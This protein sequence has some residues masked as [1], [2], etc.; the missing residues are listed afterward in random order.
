M[1]ILYVYVIQQKASP[2][3]AYQTY[4]EAANTCQEQ[5]FSIAEQ[6]SL[7]QRYCLVLEELRREAL[8][9]TTGIGTIHM[10]NSASLSNPNFPEGAGVDPSPTFQ[11]LGLSFAGDVNW[12][13][14]PSSSVADITSWGHFDSLVSTP[15]SHYNSPDCPN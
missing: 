14:S 12:N 4:L 2:V 9:Q 3:D 15:V 5:I 1:V 8:R 11:Q 13:V 7:T 10:Q 6:G